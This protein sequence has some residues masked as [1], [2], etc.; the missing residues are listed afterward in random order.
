ML[1]VVGLLTLSLDTTKIVEL[2]STEQGEGYSINT[3]DD[4]AKPFGDRIGED[5]ST[6]VQRVQLKIGVVLKAGAVNLLDQQSGE[7]PGS[8]TNSAPTEPTTVLLGVG[9]GLPTQKGYGDTGSSIQ[10]LL[11]SKGE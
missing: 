4:G 3:F 6:S 1:K 2:I 10:I 8:S 5:Y 11:L 7:Q 9:S